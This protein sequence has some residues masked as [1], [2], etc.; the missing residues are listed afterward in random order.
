MRA[1]VSAALTVAVIV[2]V[3]GILLVTT[4]DSG[5]NSSSNNSAT[6]QSVSE[7]TGPT[8]PFTVDQIAMHAS[9]DDCWTIIDGSVYDITPY[10]PRHPGGLTAIMRACGADGT[11]LFNERTAEDGEKVGSGTPHSSNAAERLAGFKVG[12]LAK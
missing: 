11:S 2:L 5:S 8:D 3:A 4:R 12:I 1:S 7:D 6:T 9:E 10:V